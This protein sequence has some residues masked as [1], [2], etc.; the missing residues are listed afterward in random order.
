VKL[1]AIDTATEA[2]SAAILSDDEIYSRFKIAPRK[3]NELI[4]PMV[5]ELLS[6]SGI[7]LLQLDAI[8]FGRGPGSFT[9]VR[10]AAGVTQGVA[11][12]GNLP[13]VPVSD[14]AA[15]AQHVFDGQHQS[16]VVAAIDARKGEVYWG[17]YTMDDN[18]N[19]DLVGDERVIP[20]E[21]VLLPEAGLWYG[22]GSGWATYGPL[23]KQQL[24]SQLIDYD[25]SVLP[26][27]EVIVQLARVE[28]EKGDTVTAELALPVYLR[29]EV[30]AK[31]NK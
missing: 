13:V 3:H 31:K 18:G 28:F 12:A 21:Q 14:L 7:T 5:E 22:A 19:A 10:I 8:A 2:C 17:C 20:P 11:F 29:N 9:G 16:K 26:S 25:G 27:A 23:L 24:G 4:L 6:E 30:V 1:L 15:I